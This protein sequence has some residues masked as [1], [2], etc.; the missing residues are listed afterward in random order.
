VKHRR[1]DRQ[2]KAGLLCTLLREG[3]AVAEALI[4]HQ[5]CCTL[6]QTALL[7]LAI[8]G[9]TEEEFLRRWAAG[10]GSDKP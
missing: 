1:G 8:A 3:D 5:G 9:V 4:V 2:K 10:E 7:M 6:R